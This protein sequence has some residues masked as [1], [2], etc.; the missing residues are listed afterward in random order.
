MRHRKDEKHRARAP[1]EAPR[2]SS[3]ARPPQNST[4]TPVSI[5]LFSRNLLRERS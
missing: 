2:T 5:A 3:R 1:Q 4:S